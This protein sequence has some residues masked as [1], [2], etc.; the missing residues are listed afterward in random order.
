MKEMTYFYMPGCPHCALATRLLSELQREDARF[1]EITVRM[2]DET[3]DKALADSYDYWYVPSFWAGETK[4][5]EGH[6][7]KADVRRALEE[8]LEA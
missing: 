8:T 4:L 2:I 7:E 1:A 3:K 5:H 6:A